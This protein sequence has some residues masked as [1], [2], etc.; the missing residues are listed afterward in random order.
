VTSRSLD[1]VLAA[2]SADNQF[3][4]VFDSVHSE[5]VGGNTALHL[6]AAWGDL[7]AVRVLIEHGADV[8]RT[9]HDRCTP[10]WEADMR[11]NLELVR[12]LV[13]VGARSIRSLGGTPASIDRHGG[14]EE[15]HQYLVAQGLQ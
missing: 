5:D 2:L 6:A 9:D 1:Q 4:H 3:D 13:S 10:L 15:V 7:E 12:Y 14:Y 8:N 11:G